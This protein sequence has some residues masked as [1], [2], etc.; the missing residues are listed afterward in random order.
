MGVK[1]LFYIQIDRIGGRPLKIFSLRRYLLLGRRQRCLHYGGNFKHQRLHYSQ[2][3]M[4]QH[5][6]SLSGTL[7]PRRRAYRD[8]AQ[9]GRIARAGRVLAYATSTGDT[10]ERQ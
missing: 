5:L 9:H 7:G 6:A 2:F 10:L 8:G 4:A 3:S 1:S